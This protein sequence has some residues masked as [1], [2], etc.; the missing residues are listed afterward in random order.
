[1]TAVTEFVRNIRRVLDD[2]GLDAD[3]GP[4]P[5]H[6]TLERADVTCAPE[7]A[8]AAVKTLHAAGYHTEYFFTGSDRTPRI[9]AW[10]RSFRQPAACSPGTASRSDNT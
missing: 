6:L 4:F 9:A 1:M 5:D 7:D 3:V 2:A 10:P 8:E